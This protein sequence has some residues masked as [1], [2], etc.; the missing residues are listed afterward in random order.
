MSKSSQVPVTGS[1]AARIGSLRWVF[2]CDLDGTHRDEY[3]F[4]TDTTM[5]DSEVIEMYGGRWNVET[6]FQEMRAHLGLKR[7]AAGIEHKF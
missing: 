1:R 5:P 2:V 6:T 3:F 4:S 7:L